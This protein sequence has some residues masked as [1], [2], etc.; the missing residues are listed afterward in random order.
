MRHLIA[1]TR[2]SD[3]ARW[4]TN[5]V[6]AALAPH[7]KGSISQRIIQTKGD[8]SLAERLAGQL[9]KGFFTAE[10][11]ASLR[12]RETDFAVHSLKDLPTAPAPGLTIGAV[13]LRASCADLLLVQPTALD[14][15]AGAVPLRAGATVGTSSVRRQSQLEALAPQVVG[16]PLRGN[17]P[18]RVKRLGTGDFDAVLLAAAGVQRLALDLSEFRAFEL[19]P[20]QWPGAPGQGAVAVQC[21]EDDTELID[22]L[23]ALHHQPTA[24]ATLVERNWLAALQGGCSTPF[25][26]FVEHEVAYMGLA[27]PQWIGNQ[28]TPADRSIADMKSYLETLSTSSQPTHASLEPHHVSHPIA[29]PL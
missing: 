26:C 28:A 12:Q 8:I 19:D 10:L 2:G 21:R 11:E 15:S 24:R 9:E 16:K 29:R 1:A 20:K 18:T 4:Q 14:T 27:Q 23:Q 3:L 22:A 13:L 7:W 17:V 5:H 6:S 25:G